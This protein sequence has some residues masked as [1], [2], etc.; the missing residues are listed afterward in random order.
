[1]EKIKNL[2]DIDELLEKYWGWEI[3]FQVY[4]YTQI[5]YN[6]DN[7]WYEYVET[8]DRAGMVKDHIKKPELYYH[9]IF[10]QWTDS[11]MTIQAKNYLG[12][13]AYG[14]YYCDDEFG[15]YG[16]IDE[17][18]KEYVTEYYDLEGYLTHIYDTETYID[19]YKKTI[20]IEYHEQ[21]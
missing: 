7:G 4:W 16:T 17:D 10:K 3:E 14:A 15:Y 20:V 5:A 6:E 19:R 12:D 18:F 1:M 2:K 13:N 21:G 11:E 9:D 8:R